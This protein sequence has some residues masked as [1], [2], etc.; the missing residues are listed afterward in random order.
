MGRRGELL[1]ADRLRLDRHLGLEPD[2]RWIF[3]LKHRL[4]GR[5]PG[6]EALPSCTFVLGPY[7]DF[8][9]DHGDSVY[10]S[11]YPVR[12]RRSGELSPPVSWEPA[13]R[14]EL[15]EEESRDIAAGIVDAFRATMPAL[16]DVRVEDVGGGVIFAWGSL[17]IDDPASEL[18]R[19][20][21][22]GVEGGDGYYSINT[23]K[24]TCAPLFATRLT[25]RILG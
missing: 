1:L 18:H 13:C 8:V 23:G 22:I 17:D 9:R 5:L 3:R 12:L 25:E 2:R 20:S 24:F 4:T 15:T 7:G 16:R 11:W 14:S 6:A 10:L 19:R 21:E